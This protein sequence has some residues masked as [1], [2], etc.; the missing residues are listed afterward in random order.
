[1]LHVNILEPG[2]QQPTVQGRVAEWKPWPARLRQVGSTLRA[3]DTAEQ[4]EAGLR[5]TMFRPVAAQPGA[6]WT[7]SAQWEGPA[8]VS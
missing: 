4:E 8:W 5:E 6:P 3:K 1:M 7:L 2:R